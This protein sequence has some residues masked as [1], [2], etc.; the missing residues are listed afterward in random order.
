LK[1][2]LPENFFKSIP[3]LKSASLAIIMGT[4]LTVHPFAAL[5]SMI[6][7]GTPRLLINREQVGDIGTRVNDV[8]ALGECD[9]QIR[10]LCKEIGNGWE[11]ELDRLWGDTAIAETATAE[12]TAMATALHPPTDQ[13]SKD[14][15]LSARLDAIAKAVEER[16]RLT[17][18]TVEVKEDLGPGVTP[19][20]T[21]STES[22]DIDRK[23][24]I[25]ANPIGGEPVQMAKL[26]SIDNGESES[27]KH[28]KLPGEKSLKESPEFSVVLP[29]QSSSSRLASDTVPPFEE[30]ELASII[31][32]EVPE[33]ESLRTNL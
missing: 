9:V 24:G 13:A 8:V 5:P 29:P 14:A 21:E 6:P 31:L 20:N 33:S 10:R 25:N 18:Y 4:S 1:L 30:T 15:N 16:L 2:Q 17:E 11:E 32:G 27:S 12:P 26:P 28:G 19:G 3:E 22:K 7:F 23:G